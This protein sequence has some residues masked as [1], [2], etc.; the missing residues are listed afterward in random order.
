M[1]DLVLNKE[2]LIKE[3][4]GELCVNS[5]DVAREYGKEHKHVLRTIKQL[6]KNI[7]EF[8]R[9][10]FGPI[11]TKDAWNRDQ[12]TYDMTEEGFFMLVGE[13]KGKKARETRLM[14]AVE[15]SNMKK[16][17]IP[18]LKKF[19]TDAYAAKEESEVKR[20]EAEAKLHAIKERQ[21]KRKK[22]KHQRFIYVDEAET[23]HDLFGDIHVKI[24]RVKKPLNQATDEEIKRYKIQHRSRIQK[25]IQDK[26]DRDLNP[27]SYGQKPG[28]VLVDNK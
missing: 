4:N 11:Y 8:G 6:I 15:F 19:A 5:L 3:V 12:L 7:G 1:N 13:F 2:N 10:S 26:Q 21:E 18:A 20:L 28:L 22:P 25:G 14:F 27:M 23:T 24:N 16:K 17:I 9:S